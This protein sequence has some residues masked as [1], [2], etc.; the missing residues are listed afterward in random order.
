MKHCL[1][2]LII[3]LT[4]VFVAI[5]SFHLLEKLDLHTWQPTRVLFS[6]LFVACGYHFCGDVSFLF[7]THF[8]L[9]YLF[10]FHIES[11]CKIIS[12]SFSST[13]SNLHNFYLL[14]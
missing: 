9:F 1:I 5:P 10:F 7:L 4:L 3:D 6:E 13:T 14:F 12:I 11:T 8:H 2:I